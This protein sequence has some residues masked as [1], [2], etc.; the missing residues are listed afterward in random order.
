MILHL[1]AYVVPCGKK[2]CYCELFTLSAAY[3]SKHLNLNGRFKVVR[4]YT[5]SKVNKL[6]KPKTGSQFQWSAP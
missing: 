4:E 3:P 6:M 5:L 1:G 2:P